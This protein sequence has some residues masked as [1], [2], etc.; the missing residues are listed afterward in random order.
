M[1]IGGSIVS[2]V[3]IWWLVLFAT[4]PI[5]QRHVWED[6]DKH[7]EGADRGAPVDPALWA[8]I[9]LTTMIAVPLWFVAFVV[10]STG[11]LMPS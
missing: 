6:P 4:L 3:M 10:V 2:F 7:P 9:K 11:V 1:G 5:G 8:K